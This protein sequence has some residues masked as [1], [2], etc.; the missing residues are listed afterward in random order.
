MAYDINLGPGQI[1]NNRKTLKRFKFKIW[2]AWLLSL[3]ATRNELGYWLP[4]S[5]V[6]NTLVILAEPNSNYAELNRK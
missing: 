6:Q 5:M 2:N 1:K 4:V 3:Q